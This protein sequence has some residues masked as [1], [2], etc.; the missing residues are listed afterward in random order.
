MTATRRFCPKANG[1]S[2]AGASNLRFR[3]AKPKK[4][5]C[6]SRDSHDHSGRLPEMPIK[7]SVSS[8]IFAPTLPPIGV[9]NPAG[10]SRFKH[11]T[12]SHPN[13]ATCHPKID[14]QAAT[15]RNAS[16]TGHLKGSPAH[17]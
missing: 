15:G 2:V 13:P 7:V 10:Y 8:C 12:D 1:Q 16:R 14:G 17:L 3:I 11:A 9:S 4:N 6:S 5:Q